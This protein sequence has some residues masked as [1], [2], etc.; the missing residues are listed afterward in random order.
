MDTTTVADVIA[1]LTPA[2]QNKARKNVQSVAWANEL[3]QERDLL[4]RNLGITVVPIDRSIVLQTPDALAVEKLT[5]T[6][7]G[8]NI[9]FMRYFFKTVV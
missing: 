9:T 2:G 8:Y 1:S 5:V 6:I 3:M 4:K 7:T